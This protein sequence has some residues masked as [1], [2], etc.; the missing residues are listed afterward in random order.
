ML[1][2]LNM[3]GTVN[4][5]SQICTHTQHAS[6]MIVNLTS[7]FFLYHLLQLCSY[8]ILYMNKY[9]NFY[10]SNISSISCISSQP[11]FCIWR[12]R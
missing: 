6:T 11:I 7:Q 12:R 8:P 3:T 2:P 4:S 1:T 10:F 9:D 5:C